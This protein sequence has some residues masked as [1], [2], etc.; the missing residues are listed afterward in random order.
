MQLKNFEKY[1]GIPRARIR[2]GRERD[3]EKKNGRK[4]ER[5]RKTGQLPVPIVK[6][7]SRGAALGVATRNCLPARK[8]PTALRIF[9][10]PPLITRTKRATLAAV[11]SYAKKRRVRL[12]IAAARGA[13]ARAHTHTRRSGLSLPRE[14]YTSF[15]ESQK[16][17]SRPRERERGARAR[18]HTLTK[19]K[20]ASGS[21]PSSSFFEG[22]GKTNSVKATHF[23][24]TCFSLFFGRKGEDSPSPSPS[25]SVSPSPPLSHSH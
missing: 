25:P 5:K 7:P 6:G 15:A 23:Y 22:H 4:E 14:P 8:S 2:D 21:L 20:G 9:R 12:T 24:A 18:A 19:L 13:P 3:P 17:A 16:F 10:A 1:S 11:N